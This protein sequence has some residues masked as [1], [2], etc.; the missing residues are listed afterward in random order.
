MNNNVPPPSDH[1]DDTLVGTLVT[2][3]QLRSLARE[4]RDVAAYVKF[5]G[6][7]ARGERFWRVAVDLAALADEEDASMFLSEDR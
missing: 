3:P 6:Q 4:L 7:S 1:L 2:T 5:L